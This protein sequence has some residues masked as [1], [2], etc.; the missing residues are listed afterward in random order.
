MQTFLD[1][2]IGFGGI[3]LVA[4]GYVAIVELVDRSGRRH[5]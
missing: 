2:I 3:A 4:L 1:I 5:G